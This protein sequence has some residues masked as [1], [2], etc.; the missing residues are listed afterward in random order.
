M[1]ENMGQIVNIEGAEVAASLI[2][3]R[4]DSYKFDMHPR[5]EITAILHISI[6]ECF[7]Y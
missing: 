3:S 1:D 6:L 7:L 2:L 5:V 4:Y